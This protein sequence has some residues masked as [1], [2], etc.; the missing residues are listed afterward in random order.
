VTLYHWEARQSDN[1]NMPLGQFLNAALI[2]LKSRMQAAR[3]PRDALE[4]ALSST[5]VRVVYPRAAFS[6]VSHT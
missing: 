2:H 1:R 5:Q 4:R 3:R 6:R